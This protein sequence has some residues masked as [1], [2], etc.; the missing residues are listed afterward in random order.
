[1]LDLDLLKTLVCV[2]DERS[3]TRAAERVHRTQSTVSQQILRLEDSVGHA[4]LQRDRT[5]K[6]VA[7]TERGEMLAGYARRLL[8][9][10]QEAEDALASSSALATVRIGL[11]EDFDARRMTAILSGYMAIAP[12]VRLETTSGMSVDLQRAL[13]AGSIDMALLKREPGSGPCIASWPEPLVWVAGTT[14]VPPA[15]EVRL[16]LY[17]QGCI[18]RLRATRSLDKADRRWRI[19]FGSQSLAGIQA[20]VASGLAVSVLPTSAVLAE[21][22]VLGPAEGYP[23]LSPCELALVGAALPLS[24][25]QRSLADYLCNAISSA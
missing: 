25:A 24:A 7:P 18:Y 12:Q 3:F 13:A 11:P 15:D 23:A 19:V 14:H 8:A 16:A 6:N 21:H 10:A 9:I 22:R 20:A 2:V 17:P 1:M 5:G 4:L